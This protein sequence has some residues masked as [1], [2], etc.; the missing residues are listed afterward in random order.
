MK[1]E[2]AM[3]T[4]ANEK[5]VKSQFWPKL[6]KNFARIPFAEDVVAAYY[7][8]VD[9]TTPFKVRGTLL[10]ALAY[11]ILPFDIIP[12]FILGLGFTDDL[13]VLM[14]AFTLVKSHITQSHRDKARQ[15]LD[16][17]RSGSLPS[18]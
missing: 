3:A 9:G 17:V 7:C 16:L 12:D 15:M 2:T 6:A 10:A 14:T 1:R 4:D 13:A 11:F 5:T 18:D 8:A